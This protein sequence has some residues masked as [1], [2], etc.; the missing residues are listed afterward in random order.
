MVYNKDF[1]TQSIWVTHKNFYKDIREITLIFIIRKIYKMEEFIKSL[2]RNI[3]DNESGTTKRKYKS[4]LQSLGRKRNSEYIAN[5][6]SDT[7]SNKEILT[8]R[9]INSNLSNN[10]WITFSINNNSTIPIEKNKTLKSLQ[11]AIKSFDVP[12]DFFFNLFEFE[13]NYD[14]ERFQASLDSSSPMGLFIIP[15]KEDFYS[16]IIERV[17]SYE[18]IRKRQYNLNSEFYIGDSRQINFKDD[19]EILYPGNDIWMSRDIHKFSSETMH[20]VILGVNG[21][22]LINSKKF[23]E[24]FNQLSLFSNKY[25]KQQFFVL[26]NCPSDNVISKHNR[27]YLLDSIINK[28]SKNLPYVFK[29]KCKY[30]SESEIP[31]NIKQ[32]I[33]NHFKLLLEVPSAETDTGNS[34]IDIFIE[35]QQT[36]LQS[37]NNILSR[38]E[39]DKFELL[40]YGAESDEHIYNKY[41]AINTLCEN[42][43]LSKIK[44]ETTE[45]AKDGKI[46]HISKPDV[47]ANSEII[48]EVETFRGKAF[49]KNVYLQLI[50]NMI[51]KSDGWKNTN[52]KELWLVVPGFEIARN[53]YQLK[54]SASIITATLKQKIGSNFKCKI[55]APDY[56]EMKIKEVNFSVVYKLTNQLIKKP[57]TH[58]NGKRQVIPSVSLG[59][60]DVIGLDSEKQ[61]MKDIIKLQEMGNGSLVKGILLYGLPGC[62]KTL[63]AKA[64][65]KESERYFFN[66]S[67]SDIATGLIGL[68]QQKI[69]DIFSQVKA[70]SPSIL[71]IDEID[72]IAFSRDT[73]DTAHT[74]QKATINQLLMEL[75][76]IHENDDDIIVIAAT[77]RFSALDSALKRS[78]R[79]DRKVPILPPDEIDRTKLFE[80][81]LGKLSTVKNLECFK[82]N[83]IQFNAL[84]KESYSFTASDIKSLVDEIKI[85]LLLNK[86]ESLDTKTIIAEINSFRN[87]GQCSINKGMVLKFIEELNLNG[88]DL[89]KIENINKELN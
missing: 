34:L 50:A 67:P 21:T 20:D 60:E 89:T 38:I 12:D 51:K 24:R 37:E 52:L 22:D 3:E 56:N 7:L 63:L 78:G 32:K 43:D 46:K 86:L 54:K 42:Y 82:T 26:F 84:G 16:T 35:L 2:I 41:F 23:E 14:Y 74:D 28:V 88:C 33:I 66:F 47:I 58:V 45:I 13:N 59:F 30:E 19:S 71:F 25:F 87:S 70:K 62:G 6:I 5:L 69:A 18:I 29:L 49:D 40:N 65:A 64:F 11:K 79:F 36:F 17:L 75:N 53:Y 55:F 76:N 15:Q 68:A 48:V 31:D 77:N 80:F 72:G 73:S 1:V 27:Q 81:Y 85:K 61:D 10:V 8:D 83:D 9:E 4:V 44:T 57:K 39:E